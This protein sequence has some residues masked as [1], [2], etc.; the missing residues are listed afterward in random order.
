MQLG[1]V[2]VSLSFGVRL[3]SVLVLRLVLGL[4]SVPLCNWLSAS[5]SASVRARVSVGVSARVRV[6]VSVR[7]STRLQL[8][9]G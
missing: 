6:S 3:G 8:G 1:S 9:L 4:G 7:V 5:V 2:G